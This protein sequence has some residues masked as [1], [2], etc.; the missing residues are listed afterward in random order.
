MSCNNCMCKYFPVFRRLSFKFCLL[1]H[2]TR[3][4]LQVFGEKEG[5]DGMLQERCKVLLSRLQNAQRLIRERK[6]TTYI[7]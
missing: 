6:K 1:V 2:V 4:V 3:K 7:T 5:E